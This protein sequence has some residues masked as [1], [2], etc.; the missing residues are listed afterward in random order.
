MTLTRLNEKEERSKL[1]NAAYTWSEELTDRS[2]VVEKSTR[3]LCVV[4][5]GTNESAEAPQAWGP[6]MLPRSDAAEHIREH[7]DT[8][9]V[10]GLRIFVKRIP[11]APY[12][13]PGGERA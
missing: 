8:T 10:R 9:S 13:R 3:S 5:C 7:E 12:L 4:T 11:A 2:V 6:S 1:G